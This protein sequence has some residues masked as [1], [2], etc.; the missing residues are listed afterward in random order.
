MGDSPGVI[1]FATH[2]RDSPHNSPG[3]QPA[4]D[5]KEARQAKQEEHVVE[6]YLP[7]AQAKAAN[8][9]IYDE[10]H[11]KSPHRVNISY[12]L[13]HDFLLLLTLFLAKDSVL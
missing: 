9:G 8:M 6:G 3:K 2:A 7:V 13:T 10:Y 5:K 1:R 4:T 11:R 12:S